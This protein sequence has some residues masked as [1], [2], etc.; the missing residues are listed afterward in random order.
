[1]GNRSRGDKGSAAKRTHPRADR[2]GG[3]KVVHDGRYGDIPLIPVIWKDVAG[4]EH[5]L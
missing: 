4:R 1:M 2:K 5:Q 3:T